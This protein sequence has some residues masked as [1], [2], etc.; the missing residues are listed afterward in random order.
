MNSV[1]FHA[2]ADRFGDL[3]VGILG[4]FCLDRYFEIDPAIDEVSIETELPVHNVVRVRT[5]P[6]GA[7]TILGNVCS[8]GV[9]RIF[10]VGF[11]GDDG[12]G[13]ELSRALRS[14][15]GVVMDHFLTTPARKTFTYTKPLVMADGQPL[16]ELNRIDIKNWSP[17]PDA[18][19]ATLVDSI[20]RLAEELDV[21]VLLE[22]VNEPGTGV[23]TPPVLEEIASLVDT[24]TNLLILA[25]SRQ[26]LGAFPPVTFKMN[27]D[28]FARLRIPPDDHTDAEDASFDLDDVRDGA[29]DLARSNG[30]TLIITMAERGIIGATPSGETWHAASRPVEGEI[31]IVG[32]GDSVTASLATSLGSGA[33]LED[34]LEIAMAAASVVIH[35]LGTTGTASPKEIS[36]KLDGNGGTQ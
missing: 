6:G 21:L 27:L 15:P 22:Q 14:L 34:A 26:G 1:Q 31:D 28:E 2:L 4:D 33:N 32:A 18:V 8:L 24:R 10:P 5:Q 9:G 36:A 25:D 19:T 20:R 17:T 13:W 7:G 35:K 16:R 30:Q 3:A 12:E 11:A 29:A 23:F